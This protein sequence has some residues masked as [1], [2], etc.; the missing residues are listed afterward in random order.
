MK[1]AFPTYEDLLARVSRYEAIIDAI[2]KGEIDAIVRQNEI[3]LVRPEE[4]VRK[5]EADLQK[6][7]AL[8]RA[9]VEDQTELICRYLQDQRITFVNRAFCD[10]FQKPAHEWLGQPL[11]LPIYDKDRPLVDNALKAFGHNNPVITL[12]HRVVFNNNDIRWLH[13]TKRIVKDDHGDY[14]EYQDVGYDIT[15]Q[16]KS[17]DAL[18]QAKNAIEMA[19]RTKNEF[20]AN[21]SHELRTPLNGILGHAQF[22]LRDSRLAKDQKETID[23]VIQCGN[24]LLTLINDILELSRIEAHIISLDLKEF[25]MTMFLKHIVEMGKYQAIQKGIAFIDQTQIDL[26]NDIVIGDDRR[27]RHIL[28]NLI[29]N[30]IKFTHAGDVTF[31]VQHKDKY[32]RFS[33]SDTGIGISK[34]QLSKINNVLNRK[35]ERQ[36]FNQDIGMGLTVCHRLVNMLGSQL[37]V[38][39]EMGKGSTFWFDIELR[40]INDNTHN[41]LEHVDS[42]KQA[43]KDTTIILP[44]EHDI[45]ELKSLARVGKVFAIETYV[46]D[47]AKTNELLIPFKLKI[48]SFTR[49]FQ[50]NELMNYLKSI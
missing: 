10:Y 11:V 29:G 2:Q 31:K 25:H 14:L 28:L 44:K 42:E 15:D 35:P 16:K 6:S 1:D 7:E 38:S 43:E 39:S 13:W 47:L 12:E 40:Y 48:E 20:L 18:R 26:K 50:L 49:V 46:A 9:I 23:T 37:H 22:L 33:V 8:Y 27:L 45:Q 24:H 17:E 5:T 3:S 4:S 41:T 36:D 19:N 21:M 34:D 30:A 32:T